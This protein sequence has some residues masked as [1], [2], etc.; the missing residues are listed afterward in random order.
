MTASGSG[1][2]PQISVANALLQAPRVAKSRN[3]AVDRVLQ[4]VRDNTEKR[5]LGFL[6]DEGVNVLKV[7]L[8]LDGVDR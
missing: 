2:D 7:N 5:P 4:L 1:L 3:L 8:A 6:G